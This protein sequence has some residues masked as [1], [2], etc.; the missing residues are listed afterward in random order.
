MMNKQDLKPIVKTYYDSL[1]EGK[2]LGRTCTKC[3]HIEF[4]PY[5]CCNACGSLDTE[6]VDM[7]EMRG[8]IKQAL[9]TIGAF[10]D[11]EFRQQQGG[12]WAVE[13][14]IDGC[15]P[16]SSSLVHVD[17]D[18][19][20]E[21]SELIRKEAVFAKPCI[22]QDEDVKVVV[23]ELEEDSKFKKMPEN[24]VATSKADVTPVEEAPC[25]GAGATVDIENDEVA[26]TVIQCAA[27]AYDADP[28]TLS[29]DTDIR[30]DLSNQSMKLIVMIS[31]I[32]EEIDV[33]IEI[34][35]A[36]YLNTLGEFVEK[37]KEKM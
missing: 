29:M 23:W 9:P 21:F 24:V 4:P 35:E 8:Q 28:S 5:L 13:V 37:V 16:I 15:D 26:K 17:Y 14:V 11:P 32:E 7:T 34:Q 33:T 30:E 31:Q 27:M 2:I 6:W 19:L 1:E 36:N 20:D 10:G 18:M 25:K 22:I 3:G 12:Y